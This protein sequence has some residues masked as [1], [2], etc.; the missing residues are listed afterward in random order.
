LN[1]FSIAIALI[2]LLGSSTSSGALTFAE[3]FTPLNISADQNVEKQFEENSQTQTVTKNSFKITVEENLGIKSNDEPHQ[4][5]LDEQT[6]AV[7]KSKIHKISVVENLGMGDG[8]YK[9]ALELEKQKSDKKAMMERVLNSERI[10]MS[11]KS[12]DDQYFDVQENPF[13]FGSTSNMFSLV[14]NVI[15]NPSYASTVLAPTILAQ[16]TGSQQLLLQTDDAASFIGIY[17][18]ASKEIVNVILQTVNVN[19]PAILLFIPVIGIVFINSEQR[20]FEFSSFRKFSSL[21]LSIILLSSAVTFPVSISTNYWG[22]AFGEISDDTAPPQDFAY[23]VPPSVESIHFDNP[24]WKDLV[25]PGVGIFIDEDNPAVIFDGKDDFLKITSPNISK[26]LSGFTV[27][28]WVKPNYDNGSPKFSVIS[29]KNAFELS[30]NNNLEPEKIATFSIFDGIKWH[31]I[32]SKSLVNEEW[33]HVAA[34]FSDS[35]ITLYING[36]KESTLEN[37]A[38]ISMEKGQIIPVPLKTLSVDSDIFVGAFQNRGDKIPSSYYSGLIDSIEIFDSA[39]NLGQINVLNEKNRESS[40]QPPSSEVKSQEK[41]VKTLEGEPNQFGFVA[42]EEQDNTQEIEKEA[43]KGF[44][45]A[46]EEKKK[47]PQEFDDG[48]TVTTSSETST[49]FS[50]GTTVTTSSNTST[51]FSDETTVTTSS[52]TS[53]AFNNGTTV[54]TS[55]NTS[56]ESSKTTADITTD[57]QKF[58]AGETVMINGTGFLTNSPVYLNVT[59]D[60]FLVSEWFVI[61][62]QIGSFETFLLYRYSGTTLSHNSYRWC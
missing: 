60:G 51:E 1:H 4:N 39:L 43:S 58:V 49:E 35:S 55:S 9:K 7:S 29:M 12:F 3:S 8:K 21:G 28:A 36:N 61:S 37:I 48:T 31:T 30:I 22:D 19:N 62:N 6:V 57:K 16:Q 46:K 24:K 41:V 47:K 15:S 13:D 10:K 59:R 27:S 23:A 11:S 52:N 32:Q 40:Y 5:Q 50:D 42:D 17:E 45:I 2:F 34:T 53:T 20:K 18:S 25:N 44:K 14:E 26:K 54:T 38:T 56:T 33:T